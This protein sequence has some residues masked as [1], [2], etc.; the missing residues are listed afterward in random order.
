MGFTFLVENAR[1]VLPKG[2]IDKAIKRNDI[3]IV[4]ISILK[5]VKKMKGGEKY[6]FRE[7]KFR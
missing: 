7:H 4:I 1:I 2:I 6:L 5:L 3:L